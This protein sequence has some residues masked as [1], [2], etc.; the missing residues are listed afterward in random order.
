MLCN[1]FNSHLGLDQLTYF[2]TQSYFDWL[3]IVR[4]FAVNYTVAEKLFHCAG[5]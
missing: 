5:N 2:H 1:V 4:S 3:V